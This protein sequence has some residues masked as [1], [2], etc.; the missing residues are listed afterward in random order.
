VQDQRPRPSLVATVSHFRDA[1]P[2]VYTKAIWHIAA[3]CHVGNI[4][5]TPQRRQRSQP[6]DLRAIRENGRRTS[7]LGTREGAAPTSIP[8]ALLLIVEPT[9]LEPKTELRGGELKRLPG[10]A[11]PP[12][13]SRDGDVGG[14][15]VVDAL[16][17]QQR[18]DGTCHR[19]KGRVGIES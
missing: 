9:L 15:S 8:L 7:N 2:G 12:V 16:R 10:F 6:L 5:R 19:E 3:E 18:I 11:L 17:L 13:H 1:T 4:G 14:L